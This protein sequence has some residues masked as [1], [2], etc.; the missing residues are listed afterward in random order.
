MSKQNP[1]TPIGADEVMSDDDIYGKA[2]PALCFFPFGVENS[3]FITHFTTAKP[4]PSLSSFPPSWTWTSGLPLF[5]P[6]TT[7]P[8]SKLL[9][10]TLVLFLWELG[11]D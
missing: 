7:S 11:I 2:C 8:L 4:H 1:T 10:F 3:L 5:I 9:A 6:P